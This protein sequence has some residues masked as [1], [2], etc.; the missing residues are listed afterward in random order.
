MSVTT[1][2]PLTPA[3]LIEEG[4]GAE[5]TDRELMVIAAGREVRDM[6]LASWHPGQSAE[7]VRPATGWDLRV[8][9]TSRQTATPTAAELEILRACD[10]AGFRT[11]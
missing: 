3:L 7:S 11:R 1:Y 9:D 8:A 6:V 10:P 5:Y 4:E 2:A